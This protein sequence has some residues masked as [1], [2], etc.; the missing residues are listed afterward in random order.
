MGGARGRAWARGKDCERRNRRRGGLATGVAIAG[1][2]EGTVDGR[3]Q[4]LVHAQRLVRGDSPDSDAR[5]VFGA[6]GKHED[7]SDGRASGDESHA[8]GGG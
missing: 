3:Q 4:W 1:D 7:R 6:R 8:R 5:G 2:G